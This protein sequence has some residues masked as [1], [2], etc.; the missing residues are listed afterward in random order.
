LITTFPSYKS[1]SRF[2]YHSYPQGTRIPEFAK[3]LGDH[4]KSTHEYIGQF[5]AKLGELANT[6]AFCVCLFL[7]SLTGTVFD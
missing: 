4:G 5:L 3:K 2:D 1:N 6:E 7:L